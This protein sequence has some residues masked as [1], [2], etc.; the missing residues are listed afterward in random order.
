MTGSI[1]VSRVGLTMLAAA[2]ILLITDA[3]LA[4]CLKLGGCTNCDDRSNITQSGMA[5]CPSTGVPELTG[6][7]GAQFAYTD[8]SNTIIQLKWGLGVDTQGGPTD[9]P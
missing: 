1:R 5:P 6:K 7:D 4:C 9:T 3:A 8:P 2:I